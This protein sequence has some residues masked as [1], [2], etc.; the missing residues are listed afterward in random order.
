MTWDL[1]GRW[2]DAPAYATVPYR[3]SRDSAP[4]DPFAY[5]RRTVAEV[6]FFDGAMTWTP[7]LAGPD[8]PRFKAAYPMPWSWI[9]SE[10]PRGGAFEPAEAIFR[11]LKRC[12]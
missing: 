4:R 3:T 8:G 6:G 1:G 11:A 5:A 7:R 9:W 2:A 12:R 10:M